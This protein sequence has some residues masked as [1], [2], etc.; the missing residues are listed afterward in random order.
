MRPLSHRTAGLYR[1]YTHGEQWYTSNDHILSWL[2]K[3]LMGLVWKSIVYDYNT[4]LRHFAKHTLQ[5]KIHQPEHIVYIYLEALQSYG[6]FT[7]IQC[8]SNK[9]WSDKRLN[10]CYWVLMARSEWMDMVPC[11]NPASIW[12]IGRLSGSGSGSGCNVLE[13]SPKMFLV[14]IHNVISAQYRRE[15][16]KEVFYQ[17]SL[18]VIC[19][20]RISFGSETFFSTFGA[21]LLRKVNMEWKISHLE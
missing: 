19:C 4:C 17:L 1:V 18:Y 11:H 8:Q 13:W 20:L 6:S 15:K 12:R 21:L 2:W 14:N 9:I 3:I 7:C 16:C 5:M 10:G